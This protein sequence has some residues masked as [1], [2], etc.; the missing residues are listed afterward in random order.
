MVNNI[1]SEIEIWMLG[2]NKKQY[3]LFLVCNNNIYYIIVY[4]INNIYVIPTLI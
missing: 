2:N 4:R 3:K 1:Y